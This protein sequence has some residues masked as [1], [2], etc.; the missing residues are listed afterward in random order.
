LQQ[1]DAA[2]GIDLRGNQ[3]DVEKEGGRESHARPLS[4]VCNCHITS[5]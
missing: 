4:D 2:G 5:P 1:G 3:H